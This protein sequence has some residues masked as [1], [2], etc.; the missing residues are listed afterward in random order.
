MAQSKTDTRADLEGAGNP[1]S[2]VNSTHDI[3]H[4]GNLPNLNCRGKFK[5]IKAGTADQNLDSLFLQGTQ[6]C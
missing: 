3:V 6:S 5:K 2:A 1:G 4:I